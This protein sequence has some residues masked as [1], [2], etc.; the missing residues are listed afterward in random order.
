MVI[1]SPS[2]AGD[3]GLI[4]GQGAE[5]SCALGSKNENINR[6]DIV[7]NSMKTYFKSIHIKKKS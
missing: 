2:V 4:P 6:N 1:T 5:L 7:T 3:G